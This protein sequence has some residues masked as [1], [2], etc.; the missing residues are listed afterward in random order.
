MCSSDLIEELGLCLEFIPRT[1]RYFQ[2]PVLPKLAPEW[3]LSK[4]PHIIEPN[5]FATPEAQREYFDEIFPAE[6]SGEA[7]VMR[8]GKRWFI[9]NTYENQ[10]I[11]EDFSFSLHINGSEVTLSGHLEPHSV[12]IVCQE[13]DGLLIH[14][15][16]YLVNTHIW[17]EPRPEK[18]VFEEYLRD[19]VTDP[20]DSERRL[21]TLRI[22]GA[23]KTSPSVEYSTEN[24]EVKWIWDEEKEMLDMQL[25][26]NGPVDL[27]FSDF[28][29]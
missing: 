25:Q 1:G 18:F 19:Y 12:L 26:H 27:T 24:G 9:S 2:L 15:N 13:D 23:G 11:S 28:Q 10:N 21:T 29:G 22:T 20:D 14:V 6:S 4:F 16:N 5:Q 3:A 8:V 7:M 17:D